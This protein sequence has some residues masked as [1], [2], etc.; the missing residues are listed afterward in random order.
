MKI[1]EIIHNNERVALIFHYSKIAP[2]VHFYTDASSL[3]QVGKQSRKKGSKIS[4]HRHIS[5]ELKST[6]TQPELLY[7]EKG[8]IK[9]IFY[10]DDWKPFEEVVLLSKDMI[11]LIQ[12]GHGFE[13]LEDT[14]MIEI[15]QGPYNPDATER[16]ESE[17]S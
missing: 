15:K 9:V 1:R 13:I 10:D 7:I 5:V 16:M 4:P 11:L 8:S 17:R 3:M 6:E 14:Q 2:G 12:G